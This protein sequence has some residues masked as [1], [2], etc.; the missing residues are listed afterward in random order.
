MRNLLK[1]KAA[2]W[3][4]LVLILVWLVYLAFVQ[5][6][7]WNFIS[8]FFAFMMVFCHL[9]ALYLNNTS[10]AAS[11]KLDLIALIMGI[12]FIVAIIVEA[13]FA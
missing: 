5:M 7:W 13:V 12:L 11:R 2:A 6:P 3:G 4:G 8:V 9:A 1:T 10:N